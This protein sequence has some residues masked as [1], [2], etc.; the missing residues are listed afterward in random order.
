[1]KAL[2]NPVVAL[3]GR[4]KF[5]YKFSLI[6]ILFLIPLLVLSSLLI[7]AEVK[8]IRF[9]EQERLGVEYIA[10]TRQLMEYIPQHRGM[11]NAYLN[12][13]ASFRARIMEAREVIGRHF[14]TLQELDSR[15]GV[16][17]KTDARVSALLEQWNSLKNNAF[18]MSASQCFQEHTQL[19]TAVIGLISHVGDTSNLLLDSELDSFYLMDVVVNQLPGMTEIMGQGRGL[20]SG[21]AA[22]HF[23]TPQQKIRLAVITVNTE[24]YIDAMEHG[25][26][27]VFE[28]NK[29]AASVLDGLDSAAVNDARHFLG[30]L[31]DRL[32]DAE[33]IDIGPGEIFKAGTSAIGSAFKL[34]DAALPLLDGI[35]AVRVSAYKNE[36]R[37]AIITVVTVILLVLLI[38]YAFYRSIFENIGRLQDTGARLVSGDL[39]ARVVLEGKDEMQ[40]V[41]AAFNSIAENTGSVIS[42]LSNSANQIAA[43]A[44]ELSA[45]SIQ[46]SRG[47][48]EQLNQTD[49]VATAINEM[50]ATSQEVARHASDA[51]AAAVS[52]DEKAGS[53]RQVVTENMSSID[54]LASEVESAAATIHTLEQESMEIGGVLEV[55]KGIAEQTN[56]LALNAAIEA[57]RAG[58]QGRGFA[59]VADE[60]R[61]LAGRTQESTEEINRMIERLQGGAKRAVAAMEKSRDSVKESVGKAAIAGDALAAIT[62]SVATINN[63]NTQIASAADEQSCVVEEV[64]K[65]IVSISQL[66]TE[67]SDGVRQVAAASE[68]LAQLAAGLQSMISDFEV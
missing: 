43:A 42:R 66:S 18:N 64:N 4:L 54:A 20:G 51:A 28:E 38:F 30:L 50:A 35:L 68:E 62:E 22:K 6:F 41:A 44:E 58:E 67:S 1:V 40:N 21:V 24:R 10:T 26:K 48:T 59:V 16:S 63:M 45:I 7:T 15:L 12:G 5:S 9:L 17:L 14:V 39:T 19:L 47:A 61:T 31:N 2:V 36:K 27:V 46:S 52:A 65:N 11:T 57:A 55:I 13:D 8:Q 33:A 23:A 53:G 56:L 60:V 29:G 32:L 3:M 34:Y 25:L 49:Q 37:V